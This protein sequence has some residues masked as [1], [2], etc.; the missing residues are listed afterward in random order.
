MDY[1][2]FDR[3]L[4]RKQLS[5]RFS[6]HDEIQYK[7]FD[8]IYINILDRH[9]PIKTKYIRENDGLFMNKTLKK[10]IMKRTNLRKKYLKSTTEKSKNAYRKQRNFCVK[11]FKKEKKK[12]YNNLVVKQITDNKKFW[13]SV[14]PLF[15]DKGL[16]SKNIVLIEK[17]QII[18]DDKEIA[19]TMS[20][21]KYRN[22]S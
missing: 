2:T 22:K 7:C 18:S 5:E 14:K 6:V 13:T 20:F 19:E 4:L 21:Y 10:A 9:A 15:T 8:E 17:E 11:P 12:Y 3:D 16:K 1:K